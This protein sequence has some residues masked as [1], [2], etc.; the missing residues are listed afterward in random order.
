MKRKQHPFCSQS[1]TLTLLT[2]LALCL[3]ATLRAD[4]KQRECQLVKI[5]TETLPLLNEPRAGHHTLVVGSEIMVVGG[6]TNGF[7]PTPTAEYFSGRHWHLLQMAYPHDYGLALPLRSGKVLIA[8]GC[9]KNLGVGQTFE[10]EMYDPAT[11]TFTGFASLARKRTLASALEI[12][13]GRVAI[14]G[15]WYANDTTELFDGKRSFSSVGQP[16]LQRSSPV[17]L[18]TSDGDVLIFSSIDTKGKQTDAS[19]VDRLYGSA[20]SIPLLQ[21]W[22]PMV[23]LPMPQLRQA[24]VG[25]GAKA[26][27]CYL[28]PAFNDRKQMAI[29]AVSD[30]TF[31]LLPTTCS[32]PMRSKWGDICYFSPVVPDNNAHQAYIVGSGKDK[33]LYV[34][35]I[36]LSRSPSPVKLL[37]TDPLP[38][39]GFSQPVITPQGDIILA[40]GYTDNN[41]TPEASTYLLRTGIYETA[42]KGFLLSWPWTIIVAA[43]L[44]ALLSLLARR[45]LS[46]FPAEKPDLQLQTE[47]HEEPAMP[48]ESKQTASTGTKEAGS[49]ETKEEPMLIDRIRKLMN[50]D[51]FFLRPEIKVQDMAAELHTNSRYISDTIKAETGMSFANYINSYRIEEAKR[52]LR[53]HPEEKII[54]VS[55]AAGF[56]NERTFF[57]TFKA[58]TGQTPKEWLQDPK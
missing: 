27:R 56:A 55:I 38:S 57:R 22:R 4:G 36:D 28:M 43:L 35:A 34:L 18:P 53:S 37:Y 44:A 58:M 32:I 20:L 26:R 45:V 17:M 9:E 1:T 31:S 12:D 8:G 19:V 14:A 42:A 41:F 5:E 39:V 13:S 15:N 52:L 30:T 10:A 54:S 33:R 23:F 48:A 25:T 40:G 21:T 16:S 11:R 49:T 47:N 51:R 46:G 2:M 7:I 3:P 24:V 29:I 6:H 50:E